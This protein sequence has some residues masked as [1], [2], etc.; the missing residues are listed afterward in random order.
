M[1]QRERPDLLFHGITV[2]AVPRTFQWLKE[3]HA[4]NQ[5]VNGEVKIY[6]AA[7]WSQPAKLWVD[8]LE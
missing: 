2:E 8:R 6:N 7:I 4:K 5:F 3:V 1:A